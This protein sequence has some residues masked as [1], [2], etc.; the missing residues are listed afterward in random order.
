MVDAGTEGLNGQEGGLQGQEQDEVV[1]MGLTE[2]REGRQ[3]GQLHKVTA[4][5]C[6]EG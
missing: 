2:T 5:N 6:T 3:T 4:R 1:E